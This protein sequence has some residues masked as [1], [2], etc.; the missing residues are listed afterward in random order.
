MKL[1]IF[2]LDQTLV[3]F[4]SFHDEA[5]R[6]LFKKFFGVDARLTEVDFS[7]KSLV[8]NFNELAR[9]KGIPTDAI[10]G[11]RSQLLETYEATFGES[12][13][14]DAAKYILPG[15]NELLSEL[16]KTHHIVVLYTGDSHRIVNLV[17]HATG[18]GKYF[19]FCFYGT[20]VEKRN[21]MVKLAIDKAGQSAGQEFR[22]KDIVI[23]GDSVRDVE[24]GRAFG[25]V[26]IAATTGIH[27]QEELLK[28]GADYVFDNLKDYRKV[29]TIIGP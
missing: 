21:D 7:G 17:L 15:V 20:E 18:L 1:I 23:I 28:A 13:P 2:D 24:C 5:V 19:K 27:S 4:L 25:A 10:E 29:L 26:V 16:S 3:D 11:E 22:N 9:L 6:R 14:R 8:E 12:L